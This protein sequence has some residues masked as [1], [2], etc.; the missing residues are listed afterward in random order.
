MVAKKNSYNMID[1][2][3]VGISNA[4][5]SFFVI[6]IHTLI[7]SLMPAYQT[8][9]M[10]KFISIATD[11]FYK[12]REFV[13]IYIP[14]WMIVGYILYSKMIP[15]LIEIVKK[16]AHNKVSVAV[17]IALVEKYARLKYK[18]I[19]D[20]KTMDLINRIMDGA[21]D[22][23]YSGITNILNSVAAGISVI[24]LLSIVMTSS[25]V[26]GL[27][28]VAICIPLFIWSV[29]LGESNYEIGKETKNIQRRYNY[30]REVLTERDYAEERILFGYSKKLIN[31]FKK[32]FD[33]AFYVYK[34]MEAKRY[35]QMKSGS[36]VTLLIVFVIAVVL[37]PGLGKGTMEV[38]I[39][40]ALI[41]AFLSLVQQMSWQ[42]AE[43]MY[44]NTRNREYIKEFSIYMNLVEKEDAL[45]AKE[46]ENKFLL[47][48]IEFKKVS[49]AY[50]G[51]NQYIL[52]DCSFYLDKDKSYAFVGENGS[53]KTTIVKLLC[54]MYDE[55]E[56]EILVNGKDIRLLPYGILKKLISVVF[57]D[58]AKYYE[59]VED[60]IKYGNANKEVDKKE[61]CDK[62]G[63]LQ[64]IHS[65]DKGM[66]TMLG[67]VFEDGVDLSEGQWQKLAIARAIYAESDLT[68]LDEP[69]A[70]LDPIAE[71][72]VYDIYRRINKS[73]FTIYITHRLGAA[74]NVDE[75][76]V[77]KNG[78]I[79][80]KGSHK[81]LMDIQNG[82]YSEMFNRQKKWYETV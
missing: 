16:Q 8:F 31:Q 17:S 77:L 12:K 33:K 52:R 30:L 74:K 78:K 25:I 14:L 21:D 47:Q 20:P 2:I 46:N 53:G 34:K 62:L 69:T 49:F 23:F 22:T 51:T 19:E 57:Q 82:L 71:S 68:I 6:A 59:R 5:G 64:D 15:S 65:L 66:S 67:H 37:M 42:F 45:A 27:L 76:L 38:G 50:P 13:D 56:G 70:S 7:N 81:Y 55:Y 10:A 44:E 63:L 29:K 11:I 26:S 9:A 61:I 48:N 40:I 41:N 54:G 58:Y 24:S 3:Y 28:I 73:K 75:I 72:N 43:I 36:F 79:E 32:L 39:Y 60:N 35:A 4:P 80:E 18:H 1:Y